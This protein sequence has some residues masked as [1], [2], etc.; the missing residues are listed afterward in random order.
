MGLSA[1]G[2]VGGAVDL[3]R[4]SVNRPDNGFEAAVASAKAP[5]R[6]TA[7]TGAGQPISGGT[8]RY[9]TLA[10][11]GRP[12]PGDGPGGVESGQVI[13]FPQVGDDPGGMVQWKPHADPF[14]PLSWLLRNYLDAREP[15]EVTKAE[16]EMLDQMDL[17]QVNAMNDI[18]ARAE[19][20][21]EERFPVPEAQRGNAP[22]GVKSER[23]KSNDGHL[24]AFRH[25]YW[26]ALMTKEFG[27][28]W[29]ERFTTLHEG[30][31]GNPAVREAMDLHNNEVG[32]RI[33]NEHPD[34]SEEELAD[35]VQ[36]AVDNGEML[37]IDRNG[38]LAWSDQVGHG[39]HGFAEKAKPG[40]PHAPRPK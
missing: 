33:A 39:Q 1:I 34:A 2:I 14:D 37:V 3:V 27:S 24:D 31:P 6:E 15:V 23:W 36:Q 8:P 16:A 5:A 28:E 11:S 7:A 22:P 13:P 30:K 12:L 9:E 29:T 20:T 25:A 32:R 26:N 38:K 10:H 4:Q 35:L 17:G 19:G 18:K 21:A 40:D